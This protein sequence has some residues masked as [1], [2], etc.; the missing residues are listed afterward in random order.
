MQV[1]E[2]GLLRLFSFWCSTKANAFTHS[3]LTVIVIQSFNL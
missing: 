1:L 2:F 3:S